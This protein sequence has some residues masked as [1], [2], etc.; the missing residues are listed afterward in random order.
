MAQV[1]AYPILK[2][3][4]IALDKCHCRNLWRFVVAEV[5]QAGQSPDSL[6]RKGAEIMLA[7]LPNML[8]RAPPS[9]ERLMSTRQMM[10]AR[11]A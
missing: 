11:F 3:N 6:V 4:M 10:D 5:N 9:E 2:Q 8:I 7:L 1:D